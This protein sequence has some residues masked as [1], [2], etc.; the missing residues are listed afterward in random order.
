MIRSK[1]QRAL[2]LIVLALSLSGCKPPEQPAVLS[3]V[4]AVLIDG[5]G[6]PPISDSVITVENGRIRAV[7]ARTSLLVPPEAEKIDGAGRFITP[8]P[9]DVLHR[10]PGP[11]GPG[12]TILRPGDPDSVPDRARRDGTPLFGDVF[13]LRDART[14]VDRGVTGFLHTIRDTEAIDPAF[15]ARL[16]D[17]RIVF[18]PMLT[19]ERDPAQLAIAKRNTKRLADGGVSIAVGS[20]GD[21]QRE[22][23]LM[24]ASGLAPADVL[25]AATRD[26]AAALHESDRRGTIEPGKRAN[27]LL[28]FA[29]PAEDIRNLRKIDRVMQDGQWR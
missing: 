14:M 20:N 3:I 9:I 16:R 1:R 21:M 6:G 15:I 28:L 12:F 24:V 11:G 4:G 22:M 8:T 26:S 18:V 19:E 10:G 2:P 23:D 17:L 13:S 27:L 7:G 25:V 29:N 5:T